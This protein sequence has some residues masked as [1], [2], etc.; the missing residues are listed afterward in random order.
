[1]ETPTFLTA[2]TPSVAI[3][4]NVGEVGFAPIVARRRVI[5]GDPHFPS[6][7]FN[8]RGIHQIFAL[9]NVI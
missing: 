5:Y 6:V 8:A 2:S 7:L 9:A 1:M 4:K 3:A